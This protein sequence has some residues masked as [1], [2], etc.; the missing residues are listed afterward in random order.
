MSSGPAYRSGLKLQISSERSSEKRKSL[1]RFLAVLIAVVVLCFFGVWLWF[2]GAS[3]PQLSVS[4]IRTI[5]AHWQ[6]R[7]QFG[8]TN[9]SH[10]TVFTSV[11]GEVEVFNHTNL[12]SVGATSPMGRLSPGEGAGCRSGL[13]AIGHEL[14]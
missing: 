7:L 11:N 13:I 9:T 8:I 12:L 2:G 3:D 1:R 4:Y 5:D 6:W 14:D 10:R